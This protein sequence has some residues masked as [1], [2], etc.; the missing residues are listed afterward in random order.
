MV[1]HNSETEFFS[2]GAPITALSTAQD[3][4]IPSNILVDHLMA[5]LC[6]LDD[7]EIN[8]FLKNNKNILITLINTQQITLEQLNNVIND[9]QLMLEIL[10]NEEFHA[11]D[12]D[13]R[14]SYLRAH[15]DSV[16]PYIHTANKNG[17]VR[18]FSLLDDKLENDFVKHLTQR[19]SELRQ[20]I[21]S[22]SDS[23][24]QSMALKA[25]L[26]TLGVVLLAA[27]MSPLLALA[28]I[29]LFI[30]ALTGALLLTVGACLLLKEYNRYDN[31]K[32]PLCRNLQQYRK[33]QT[34]F[35]TVSEPKTVELI[36]ESPESHASNDI[37]TAA[38]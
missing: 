8:S 28:P 24:A 30:V 27:G 9:E 14:D 13:L 16:V 32:E 26:P 7:K 33:S 3:Q 34:L 22:I 25:L 6:M 36:T 19:T 38:P 11:V 12:K 2:Q 18:L 5:T 29:P 37:E 31:E 15:W 35:S 1:A 10:L 17:L 21:R 4:K 20:A 23:H